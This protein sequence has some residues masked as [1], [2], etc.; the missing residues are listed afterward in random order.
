MFDTNFKRF[1]Y[2]FMIL[3]VKTDHLG[4]LYNFYFAY[5]LMDVAYFRHFRYVRGSVVGQLYHKF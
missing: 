1:V 3:S 2:N 4:L 5:K